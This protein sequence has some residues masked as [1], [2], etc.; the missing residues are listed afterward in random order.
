MKHPIKT[1]I[2][3]QA[4]GTKIVIR[5]SVINMVQA[6]SLLSNVPSGIVVVGAQAI[7]FPSDV[8]HKVIEMLDEV[9]N[10]RA[11]EVNELLGEG[12]SRN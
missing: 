7:A 10:D 5:A 2:T 9:E 8:C 3:L 4:D 1:Y 12:V 6:P 11:R